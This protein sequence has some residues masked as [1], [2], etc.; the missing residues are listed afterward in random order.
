MSKH[1]KTLCPGQEVAR[2]G[3]GTKREQWGD[4]LICKQNSLMTLGKSWSGQPLSLLLSVISIVVVVREGS[5]DGRNW[6]EWEKTVRTPELC[7]P[8]QTQQCW[9]RTVRTLELCGP[10]SADRDVPSVINEFYLHVNL[11]P[12]HSLFVPSPNLATSWPGHRVFACL[13]MVPEGL[14]NE[15]HWKMSAFGS[16]LFHEN[17]SQFHPL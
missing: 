8:D 4:N 9:E 15:S 7:G 13:L 2:F 10:G 16:R 6:Q 14:G 11:S 3:E 17:F 12:H 1:A 5:P